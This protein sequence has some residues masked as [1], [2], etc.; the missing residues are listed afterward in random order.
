MRRLNQELNKKP[1]AQWLHCEF[2]QR[3]NEKL[4]PILFKFFPEIEKKGIVPD[5][6]YK[7]EYYPD[8]KARKKHYK[9]ITD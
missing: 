5:T 6:F 1:R 9:K 4:M 7:I 2:Y 8:T 3:L